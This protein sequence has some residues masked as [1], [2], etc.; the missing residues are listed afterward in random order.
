MIGGIVA[1]IVELVLLPVKARTLLV[2]SIA[3]SLR[4]ISEMEN[5]IATGIEEGRNLVN[6]LPTSKMAQFENASGKAKGALSA[7]ETFRKSHRSPILFDQNVIG[8][9]PFCSNEPRI[10]GSFENLAVIYKEVS[11]SLQSKYFV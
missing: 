8:V 2:E 10:K 5:V 4:Q 6:G 3:A 7:A 9:V 1:L 11:L